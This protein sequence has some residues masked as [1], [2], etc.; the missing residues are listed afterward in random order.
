MAIYKKKKDY[1]I[2]YYANGRR[3]REKIGSSKTLAEN[4]LRKRKVEVAEGKHLD[5]RKQQKIKFE[6]FADDN[7][8]FMY[9][10]HMLVHEDE[11]MMG[12]FTV[13]DNNTLIVD[14]NNT[15][16]TLLKTIDI[17]GRETNAN[18]QLLFYIYDDGTVEKK[19]IIE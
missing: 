5:I 12:Q 3:I 14:H 4:V 15:N 11:G 10:C 8:P 13:V 1:Y 18:N 2:D 19:I 6:D 9:H 7:I 16:K 17:F